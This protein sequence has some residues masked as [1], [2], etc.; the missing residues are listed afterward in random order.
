MSLNLAGQEDSIQL[1]LLTYSPSP[2]VS[3]AFGHSTIRVQNF[4]RKSDILFSYGIYDFDEPNFVW[5]FLRGKLEYQIGKESTSRTLRYYQR[6]GNKRIIEQQLLLTQDENRKIVKFLNKNYLPENRRYLYDFFFDNCATRVRDILENELEGTFKYKEDLSSS[7]SLRKL[8]DTN[9]ASRPWTDFGMDLLIGIPSDKMAT[10]Q[11]Q[12]FLPEFLSKNL[13]DGASLIRNGKET[14]LFAAP[15]TLVD[16]E[17]YLNQPNLFRPFNVFGL[18]CILLLILTVIFRKGTSL[19]SIDLI[20]FFLL[21]LIGLILIFMWL[22][23]D[24]SATKW[25]LNILWANP[26][27]LLFLNGLRKKKH[28][29]MKWTYGMALMTSIVILMTWGNFPQEFHIGIIPLILMLMVRSGAVLFK[30]FT[31]KV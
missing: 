21:G 2:E 20:F 15:Q 8:L 4:T 18:I 17:Y 28:T 13:N 1:S 23:T 10:Y 7:K 3:G 22:G 5:K 16:G 14:P 9:I 31:K 29:A 11:E 27:Y 12:M 26:L 24:H 30:V 25:N 6:Q 19:I